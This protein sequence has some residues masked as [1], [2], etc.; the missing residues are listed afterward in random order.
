HFGDAT[1]TLS[2]RSRHPSFGGSIEDNVDG[3][4]VATV[5]QPPDG[6]YGVIVEP[7]ID[8][9]Q[10]GSNAIIHILFN[11]RLDTPRPIGPRHVTALDGNLW[12]VGKVK[13]EN[14]AGEWTTL[15]TLIRA[16]SS[17]TTVPSAWPTFH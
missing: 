14:G 3:P 6:V 10:D 13:I 11:G 15:D 5:P 7:V 2:P 1:T 4:A 8:G 9:S 17:P 12:V 16:D